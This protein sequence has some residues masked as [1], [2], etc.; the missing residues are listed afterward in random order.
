MTNKNICAGALA[1]LLL[2]SSSGCPTPEGERDAGPTDAASRDA[3]AVDS[4]LSDAMLDVGTSDVGM[5]DGDAGMGPD[6]AVITPDCMGPTL[7]VSPTG[8]DTTGDGSAANPWRSLRHATRSVSGAGTIHLHAGTYLETETSQLPVGVCL[9]GE[10]ASTIVRSTLTAEYTAIL[11]A[12]SPEG[13]S[14]Q[15]SISN[16]AFDGTMSTRWAIEIRGRSDMSIHHCSFDDFFDSAVLWGGR[17]GGGDG[18]P[19]IFATGNSFHHNTASNSAHCDGL[20]CRGTLYIGGQEGMLIHDNTITTNERG[21]LA[22]GWPI[23]AQVNDGYLRGV[24]IFNNRLTA[25]NT[26]Y[27]D[28]A[29]ELFHV[30]GVEVFD[31]TISGSVDSN[32]QVLEAPYTFSIR[33]HHNTITHPEP[34]PMIS[35]GGGNS[36]VILEFATERA[37]VYENRIDTVQRCV[38]FT[39]R[40]ETIRNVTVRNN[41]CTNIS[42]VGEGLRV[43]NEGAYSVDGLFIDN[44]TFVGVASGERMGFGLSLPSGMRSTNIRVRNNIIQ[45]C[46]FPAYTLGA[47]SAVTGLRVENN[48]FHDCNPEPLIGSGMPSDYVVASTLTSDP[49]LTGADLRP[50]DGS[51]AIDSGANIGLPFLGSAPDRGYIEVR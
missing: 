45:H 12:S 39:P 43:Q 30:T 16:I 18:P 17:V 26:S 2:A 15:Q 47:G 48:T 44:N 10:G 38:F 50:A 34:N 37:E 49:M 40:A 31:N 8:S 24:R 19:G 29:I 28:F 5:S 9:E 3:G 7:H 6:A 4:P 14:G 35:Y 27:F 11:N 25:S 32:D 22:N 13:T 33:V 42:H 20:F 36:G 46:Q 23:K 1:A 21:A 41:L 51:P